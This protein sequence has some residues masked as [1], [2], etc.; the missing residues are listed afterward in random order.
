M[1][2]TPIPRKRLTQERLADALRSTVADEAMCARAAAL[3]ERIRAEDGVTAAV[4]IFG[5]YASKRGSA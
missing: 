1:G 3:G 2:P 4:E 5:R